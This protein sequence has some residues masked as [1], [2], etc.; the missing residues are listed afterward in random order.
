MDGAEVAAALLMSTSALCAH[1]LIM[2]W[3]ELM[4]FTPIAT[5]NLYIV[6]HVFMILPMISYVLN[7]R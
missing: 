2:S 1:V 3:I 7:F 4:S 5:L 6:Y